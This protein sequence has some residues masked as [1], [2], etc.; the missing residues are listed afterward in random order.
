MEHLRKP[1]I[2]LASI[3]AVLFCLWLIIDGQKV[4]GYPGA[5]QQMIGLSGMIAMLYFYNRS[6]K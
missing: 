6:Q 5:T 2:T 4:V 1:L 3:F